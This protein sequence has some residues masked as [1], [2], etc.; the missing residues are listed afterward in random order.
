MIR[1]WEKTLKK[2]NT[3]IEILLDNV[4]EVE[5]KTGILKIKML[6]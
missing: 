5:W 2:I 3:N 6:S 1:F 4:T